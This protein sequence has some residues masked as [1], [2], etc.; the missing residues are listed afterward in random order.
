MR[1]F[2]P[3]F[4]HNVMHARQLLRATRDIPANLV[5]DEVQR[6]WLRSVGYGLNEHDRVLF[7]PVSSAKLRR[8][9]EKYHSLLSHAVPE[10]ERLFSALDKSLW[11]LACVEGGEAS[12]RHSADRVPRRA[13]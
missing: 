5:A 7:N 10:M 9:D 11:V 8:I 3:D 6:S 1:S 13:T 2:S 12:S 4:D